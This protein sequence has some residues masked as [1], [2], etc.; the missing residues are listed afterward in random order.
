MIRTTLLARFVF[1]FV[2][3]AVAVGRSAA[4]AVPIKKTTGTFTAGGKT[5]PVEQFEPKAP[6]T[7]PAIVL[8]HGSDGLEKCGYLYRFAAKTI[9]EDGYVVLLVHYMER[10]GHKHIEPG[11]IKE[12]LFRT[13]METVR[14]AVAHARGLAQ[15][16]G[17]RVGLAGLS[18][19]AFLSLSLAT[20]PDTK[21]AAVVDWFGG[22]PSAFHKDSKN[23][24]P[25]LIIHGAKDSVVPVREALA[26][27]GMLKSSKRPHE[28][29]I[30]QTQDHMFSTDP[31]GSDLA[32][33]RN[34]TLAFLAK[35]VKNRGE[36]QLARK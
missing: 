27:E 18:L 15:V 25:T 19:G 35:H 8:V 3:L 13:W 5:I 12:E 33:A 7:Y 4:D 11:D 14:L 21:I 6:G 30:F 1:S 26:L 23:L 34:R 31:F 36:S 2:V 16:D 24:P 22:L 10:T 9:A 17:R 20:S 32:E 28:I 29:K